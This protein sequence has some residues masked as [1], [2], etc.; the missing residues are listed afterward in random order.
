[1]T[2]TSTAATSSAQA[3]APGQIGHRRRRRGLRSLGARAR[4][5]P[6]AAWACALVAI[7]SAACWSVV[8]PPFQAP[9]EPA[10][11]AYVEHLAQTGG[12]PTSEYVY[13]AAETR[14]LLDLS[15]GTLALHPEAKAT[16]SQPAQHVLQQ[17][18]AAGLSRSEPAGAGVAAPEPPLY[19]A[20]EAIPYRLG[21]AVGSLLDSLEL[22]R[23]L[24]ALL[25]GLTALFSYMFVREALPSARWAWTVGGLGVALTPVLGFTSSVVTP[26]ALLGAVSAA[27]FYC[28][29]RGFR[30]G[31]TLRLA[32]SIGALVAA[33]SL[34]KLNFLGLLPGVVLG[35]VLLGW[36]GRD[37]EKGGSGAFGATALGLGVGVSPGLAYLAYALIAGHSVL[38]RFSDSASSLVE[39]GSLWPKLAYIWEFYLP[40]LPGMTSQFVGVSPTRLWFDRAVG[41]YG[42][43]DTSFPRWATNAAI[44]PAAAIVILAL[45]ALFR[46]RTALVGRL[47]ELATYLVMGVG[48][49]ALIATT[50]Y[51]SVETERIGYVQPRYMLP[52]LPLAGLMLA[53]AAR[54][55]GRRWGP[56]V[57]VVLVVLFLAHDVFS[58]LLVVARFYG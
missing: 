43:L 51:V 25:A 44:A 20:L 54:G 32:A 57:G 9:D 24:S 14:M 41:L 36:R 55:A 28:L 45:T 26:D 8:T 31:L 4:R 48:L 56:P 19:Y 37:R 6:A 10:H 30:R 34:T 40:R 42:W 13:P 2:T 53:L 22:M 46:R 15:Q 38:G 16:L 3:Q 52:L 29:A 1:M 18:L 47:T 35:L 27:I 21:L 39:H 11:F 7:L 5:V 49:L 12:L 58:Q 50:A 23:L 33:G 17:D